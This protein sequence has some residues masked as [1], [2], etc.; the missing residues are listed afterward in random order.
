MTV[1]QLDGSNAT[2]VPT[3]TAAATPRAM[4]CPQRSVVK[5]DDDITID[6]DVAMD[7]PVDIPVYVSAA[8]DF[9]IAADAGARGLRVHLSS[10]DAPASLS[11]PAAATSLSF[12]IR[13]C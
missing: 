3:A 11:L 10:P 13:R 1:E 4:G 2:V 5:I 7:I 8:A 12:D 9:L 6:I